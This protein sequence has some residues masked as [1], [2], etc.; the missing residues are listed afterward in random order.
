LEKKK[1]FDVIVLG[2]GTAGLSAAI[3][4]ADHNARVL[5]LEK[6][7]I[8]ARGGNARYTGGGFNFVHE[9]TEEI[10]EFLPDVPESELKLI[11]IPAYSKDDFFGDLMR[12]SRGLADPVLCE[13]LVKESN[14]TMRWL[15]GMG[16]KSELEY[17]MAIKIGERWQ[18]VKGLTA[19]IHFKGGGEGLVEAMF[20]IAGNKGVE[21]RYETKAMKLLVDERNNVYGVRIL[22]RGGF[23]DISA[24]AII[25]ASG[26]F[27]ANPEMRTKYLGPKWDLVK[28]RGSRYNTGEGLKMAMEI[29]AQPI[30]HWSGCHATIVD[31]DAP[32]VDGGVETARKSYPYGIMVNQNGLRFVDEGEDFDAYTYAKMG[33]VILSQPSEMAFQIFDAK[34]T[35]LLRGEYVQTVP[36]QADSIEELAR[37]IDVDPVN[38]VKTVNEFNRAVQDVKFEAF[39]RDGKRTEGILPCKSN[40]AQKID[41]PPFRAYPVTIGITFTFGGIKT[42]KEAR[43]LNT[44]GN[45]IGNLYAAGEIAGGIFYYN[46]G[47]GTGIGKCITF[48]RIAGFNAAT[49]GQKK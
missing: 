25:I 19:G 22:G 47:G 36:A 16:I 34:V 8:A 10:R 4:A 41:T 26:G 48:G 49:L 7:P 13:T 45:P 32:D 27:Q 40:W 31:V 12:M 15:D 6:T 28:V 1:D 21:I 44:E 20:E 9:G 39:T 14:S 2:S 43:V 29:G 30:G 35:S 38:L 46:Y 42:D 18:F 11:D 24:G 3:E 5:V 17:N 37:E 33:G 23:Q